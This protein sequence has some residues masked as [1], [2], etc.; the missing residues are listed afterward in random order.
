[1][2]LATF[3]SPG[4]VLIQLGPFS[5]RWYGLLIATAVLFGLL[6]KPLLAWRMLAD[7]VAAVE[8]ALAES[9]DTR[10]FHPTAPR[11]S[12]HP[13]DLGLW[14]GMVLVGGGLG[15][16]TLV[17]LRLLFFLYRWEIYYVP[18]LRPVYHWVRLYL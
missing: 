3:T 10:G 15:L 5:L 7:E 16:A 17:G 6:L 18:T 14:D 11:R 9:L 13:L 1:M 12:R 2:L 4:P 8:T